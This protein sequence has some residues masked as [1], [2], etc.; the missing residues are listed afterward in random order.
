[1]HGLGALLFP[2]EDGQLKNTHEEESS[3]LM[4]GLRILAVTM[5]MA[6][7]LG[8]C[9]NATPAEPDA[10]TVQLSWFH[11]A[12]FAGFYAAEEQGF[13]ADEN[14][15]VTLV[16]GGPEID[17][18]TELVEGDAQ[19]A[20]ATGDAVVR[21]RADG[22]EVKAVA[23]IYR[24]SPLMVMSMAGSGIQQP[25]DLEG[26]TVGVISSDLHTSYDIQFIAMLNQT[27][28]EL[29]S[30]ELVP[31][32]EYYGARDLLSGRMEAASGIFSTNERAQAELEGH[33]VNSIFY[34]DYGVYVYANP[35]ITTDAL[36]AENPELV[37]RFV[38][39]TMRGYQFTL[40]NPEEAVAITLDYDESLDLEVQAATH[41]AQIPLI[42]TGTATLGVMEERVWTS[43][44][45]ILLNQ[46]IIQEPQDVS[47]VYTNE[48][49]ENAAQ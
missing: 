23:A 20:V 46:G 11:T 26:K 47:D 48:F 37:Q 16:A 8:A 44:Q 35:I 27:G 42:D 13:Y 29:D 18:V 7:V 33:E 9:N 38:D 4:R 2:L 17:P 14:L 10:V 12:E 22:E 30:M 45:D 19:F 5:V 31:L 24:R 6:F 34:S 39:A 3:M 25:A 41:Q 43:T 1:V 32:E 28:V 15:D 40:E 49:V 21:A 36:I